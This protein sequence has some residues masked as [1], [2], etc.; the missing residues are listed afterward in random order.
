M[1]IAKRF[2]ALVIDMG[3]AIFSGALII[4]GLVNLI[5]ATMNFISVNGIDLTESYDSVIANPAIGLSILFFWVFGWPCILWG[6][7]TH[8]FRKTLG[9]ALL[10]L[11]VIDRN[12]ANLTF[13]QALGR[14]LLKMVPIMIPPLWIFPLLQAILVETTFYDQVF[15]SRVVANAKLSTVQENFTKYY[16]KA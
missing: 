1:I 13:G 15:G 14:E 12:R 11:E 7:T 3:A 16:N 2:I 6:F 4:A 5:E 9:K 10:K 8:K